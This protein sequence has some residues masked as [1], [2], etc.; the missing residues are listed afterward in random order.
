MVPG[1]I[2]RAPM[3]LGVVS[4]L[5]ITA[6]PLRSQESAPLEIGSRVRVKAGA[7]QPWVVGNLLQLPADSV[8]LHTGDS[9][10]SV[11]L[12][13]SSL[14]SFEFSRGRKSQA[15]R[16][17][18]IGLGS[19]AIIGLIVGA[20][21]YEDCSGCLAPDPGAAGSAVLGAVLFGVFGLGVGALIGGSIDAER[22]EPVPP[23]W[24][25][26]DEHLNAGNSASP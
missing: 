26:D 4:F 25:A 12:A 19:G 18:W 21:T 13:T 3:P 1:R 23:P 5:F 7:Q 9:V 14:A 8:W 15:G 22:W 6:S 17:A 16:G 2:Q 24:S 20:A 10:S 11:A